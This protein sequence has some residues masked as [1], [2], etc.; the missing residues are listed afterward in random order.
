MIYRRGRKKVLK[1]G[2][3]M[4]YL[5]LAVCLVVI[6]TAVRTDAGEIMD[7]RQ[8]YER[9]VN[10]RGRAVDEAIEKVKAFLDDNPD[11]V[12]AAMYQGSLY[13]MCARDSFF[14]WKKLY[15]LHKGVDLMDSAM[16]RVAEAEPHGRD[17][18]LEMLLIRAVT[19]ARIPGIFNRAGLARQDFARII[20]HED[21]PAVSEKMR[22]EALAW[23]ALY[24][25][26][27]GETARA[28]E[29][30]A[31]ARRLDAE[32]AESVWSEK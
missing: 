20:D 26:E 8:A 14:P 12:L 23:V 24:A 17:P 11:D 32:A 2:L 28:E 25:R 10:E 31:E 27:D 3:S 6:F 13:T 29:T 18:E 1:A 7:V 16:E 9:A 22:A 4:S 30:M 15:Y 21:F 19:N 5:A